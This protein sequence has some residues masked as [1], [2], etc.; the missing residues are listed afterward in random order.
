[1]ELVKPKV[2]SIHHHPGTLMTVCNVRNPRH[3]AQL[4][5]THFAGACSFI[6]LHK[7]ESVAVTGSTEERYKAFSSI[8]QETEPS[9]RSLDQESISESESS[10]TSKLSEDDK[11]STSKKEDSDIKVWQL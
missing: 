11:L 8:V 7:T 3:T 9:T 4:F 6:L 1:V 5:L 2:S 10:R